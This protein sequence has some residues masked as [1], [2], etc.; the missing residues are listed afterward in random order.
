MFIDAGNSFIKIGYDQDGQWQ[1]LRSIPT[2]HFLSQSLETLPLLPKCSNDGW[3]A[4]VVSGEVVREKIAAWA[5]RDGVSIHFPLPQKK[6]FGIINGYQ[7]TDA[8]GSDRYLAL[9]A[10]R[11]RQQQKKIAPSLLVASFGTAVTIDFLSDDGIF[12]GGT[13]TAGLSLQRLAL[14]VNTADLPIVAQNHT[15]YPVTATPPCTTRDAITQGTWFSMIGAL[16][17]QQKHYQAQEVLLTGGD[18]QA[19]YAYDQQHLHTKT[20]QHTPYL[21]F[22]GL[23]RYQQATATG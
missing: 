16:M 23:L 2:Q 12:E 18:A 13:I 14:N 6:A 15:D 10:A 7:P 4:S 3:W 5:K 17:M 20:W 8:L 11:H 9:I 19:V 21:V 22:E 1:M